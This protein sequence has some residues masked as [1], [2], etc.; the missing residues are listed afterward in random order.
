MELKELERFVDAATKKW[1]WEYHE[2]PNHGHYNDGYRWLAVDK[3]DENG[4]A[5]HATCT[6]CGHALSYAPSLGWCND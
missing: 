6:D 4:L 3:R 1:D 5:I 2:C